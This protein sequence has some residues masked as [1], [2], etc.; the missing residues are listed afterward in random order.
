[1]F[2]TVQ[3]MLQN[4]E[5]GNVEGY[6]DVAIVGVPEEISAFGTTLD[7]LEYAY[8]WTNN[9]EGSWSIKKTSFPDPVNGD[10][11]NGDYNENVA[12]LNNRPDGMGQRS[13]M[14]GDRM[15]VDGETYKVAVFGFTKV[16][17]ETV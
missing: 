9:V 5:T 1:M 13:T 2:I 17:M 6:R 8:R 12:V 4:R 11:V 15:E 16:E 3:H 7:C 10:R 14:M